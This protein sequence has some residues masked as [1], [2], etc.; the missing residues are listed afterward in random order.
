MSDKYQLARLLLVV[1]AIVSMA[2]PAGA[3]G[4]EGFWLYKDIDDPSDQYKIII[5]PCTE[6]GAEPICATIT[7][8]NTPT[9]KSGKPRLDQA[10]KDPSQRARALLGLRISGDLWPKG[11]KWKG[12][13]YIPS[14]GDSF[15]ADISPTADGL[16][17]H[18]GPPI[19]GK[20]L[21]L[22]PIAIKPGEPGWTCA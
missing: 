11:G 15:S 18:V 9:N 20:S 10:N 3:V 17:A 14:K 19:F 8:M 1:P 13:V 6:G 5:V 16:S 12:H 22:A 21:T 2:G 7:C 4:I